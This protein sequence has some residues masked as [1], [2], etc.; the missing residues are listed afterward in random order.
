MKL[1]I[2]DLTKATEGGIKGIE[3]WVMD[4][5]DVVG[6]GAIQN[7]L[8]D[9]IKNSGNLNQDQ[10]AELNK[11][12]VAYEQHVKISTSLMQALSDIIKKFAAGA[13]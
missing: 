3:D 5:R 12:N 7:R 2:G 13:K 4:G 6:G 8:T 9:A 1:V 10:M 11:L